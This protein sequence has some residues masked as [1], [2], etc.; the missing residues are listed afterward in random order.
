MTRMLCRFEFPNSTY[1]DYSSDTN[2]CDSDQE[3]QDEK[4]TKNRIRDLMEMENE[5]YS[6]E[7]KYPEA[8]NVGTQT[9]SSFKCRLRVINDVP[10]TYKGP[11]QNI[12]NTYYADKVFESTGSQTNERWG[13]YVTNGVSHL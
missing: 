9:D 8:F 6:D 10:W 3:Y 1:S 7:F 13:V 2:D 4:R 12:G 5:P 11:N